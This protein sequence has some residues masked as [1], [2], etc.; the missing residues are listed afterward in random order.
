VT[1][2]YATIG[3]GATGLAAATAGLLFGARASAMSRDAKT[4]CAKPD[5]CAPDASDTS[6]AGDTS[7]RA[8]ALLR[9]A[10]S[11]ARIS[12]ALVASGCAATIASAVLLLTAPRAPDERVSVAPVSH[13]GGAG[14]AI[15]GRF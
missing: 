11:D 4:L 6:A 8:A 5:R 13:R 15:L 2:K 1:R 10:R 14:L 7:D 12:T 3:L 9:D